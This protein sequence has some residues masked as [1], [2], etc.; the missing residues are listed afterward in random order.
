MEAFTNAMNA[1]REGA[2][3][4]LPETLKELLKNAAPI[5]G[6]MEHIKGSLKETGESAKELTEA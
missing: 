6:A 4:N 5:P 1:Y 2:I 3:E